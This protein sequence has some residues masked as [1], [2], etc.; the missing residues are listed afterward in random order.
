LLRKI[1]ENFKLPYYTISPTYSVCRTHGYISG[2]H[3]TCPECGQPAEVYSRITGYY[4][5]VKNW[6][7]GKAQE[8]KD[9]RVYSLGG[10]PDA[11]KEEGL[12]LFT[13]S[14]CPNCSAAKNALNGA[15]L[16]YNVIDAAQNQAL[17]EKYG[18]LQAPTLVSVSGGT[19][20][21]TP[22]LAGVKEY[23]G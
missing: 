10:E 20:E 17:V 8:F 13:T 19:A 2:E 16:A 12:L 14:T 21:K 5:P 15:G 23:I 4:R 7:E 18:V 9:R 3:Y 1:A 22:G 6:N 11:G